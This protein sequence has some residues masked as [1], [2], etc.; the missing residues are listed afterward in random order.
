MFEK[1][2]FLWP[3]LKFD[4]YFFYKSQNNYDYICSWVMTRLY[5]LRML[6]CH[7]QTVCLYSYCAVP[8]GSGSSSG[9]GWVLRCVWLGWRTTGNG[10]TACSCR[11]VSL[12]HNCTG[13]QSD[14][15]FW[16]IYNKWLSFNLNFCLW[17]NY[18]NILVCWFSSNFFVKSEEERLVQ[19]TDEKVTA[20]I[21]P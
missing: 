6:S 11:V 3:S 20:N 8:L 9:R 7:W 13:Y 19:E 14:L 5:W 15:S 16:F 1:D 2:E 18:E 10:S 21:I 17:L 12:S 4:Y